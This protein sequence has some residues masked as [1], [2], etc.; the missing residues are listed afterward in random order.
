MI[1]NTFGL[2]YFMRNTSYVPL[3][4]IYM[5]MYSISTTQVYIW[6]FYQSVT[7]RQKYRK[8]LHLA[9]YSIWCLG[10]K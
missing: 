4:F 7:N 10:E 2:K 9:E 1:N 3:S 6:F 8:R 5:F